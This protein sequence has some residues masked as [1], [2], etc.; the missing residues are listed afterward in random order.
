MWTI[1]TPILIIGGIGLIA[2]AGLSIASL[3]FAVPVNKTQEAL[4]E[5]FATF[6]FVFLSF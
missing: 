2:G 4:K 3:I 1:L 6:L 5:C